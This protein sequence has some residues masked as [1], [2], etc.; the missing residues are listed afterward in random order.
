LPRWTPAFGGH[1]PLPRGWVGDPAARH[2]LGEE[3]RESLRAARAKVGRLVG[4]RPDG[5]VSV[6]GATDANDLAIKGVALRGPGRHVVTTAIEHPSV[7]DTARALADDGCTITE[8]PVDAGGLVDPAAVRAAIGDRTALVSIGAAAALVAL[9]LG[10]GLGSGSLGLVS[11]AQE[12]QIG[13]QQYAPSR[14]SQGGDYVTDPAVTNYVRQVGNKLAAVADRKLPYEFV[15]INSSD[16]NAWAL[17]GG[18]LAIN[19]LRALERAGARVAIDE[20][21]KW[22]KMYDELFRKAK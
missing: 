12:I 7:L 19:A 22:E 13:Q 10:A 16:L 21:Q 9:K 3:A 8:L 6:S 15:V 18:K 11:E 17:P 1:A 20:Y 5:V 2:G 4:G 14:Q